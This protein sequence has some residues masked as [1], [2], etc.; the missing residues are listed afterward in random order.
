MIPIVLFVYQIEIAT[1]EEGKMFL[2]LVE[3]W[4]SF[5]DDPIERV[6]APQTTG[7]QQF[8]PYTD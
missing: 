3:C 7:Q 8:R 2:I 1:F 4:S 5:V 6:R